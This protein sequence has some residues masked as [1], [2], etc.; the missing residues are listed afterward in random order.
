MPIFKSNFN[1]RCF[2]TTTRVLSTPYK[3]AIIGTG[4]G[5]FYTAHHLLNKSSSDKQIQLD[6]FEKLPTP[7]GLSRY[8]VAPDHPEVKNCES[9]M[10]DLMKD[11]G[12]KSNSKNRV[13]F[14]GNIEIGKDLSLKDLENH[15]NSIVLAYGCTS[16]DNKLNIPGSNLPGIISARKFVN[17]YNG[18]PDCYE[19]NNEYKPPP[20]DKIKNVSIIG[21][22]NVALDVARILLANPKTHWY[23][24]DISVDAEKLLE[25]SAVKNVNIVARRGILES[26]FSNKEIRELFELKDA[27]FKPLQQG[28]LESVSTQKLGRVDKRKVGLIEKYNK[29]IQNLSPE[30]RTWSLQYFKSPV[31]FIANKDGSIAETKCVVNKSVNDPLLPGRIEPT[32]KIVSI[33]NDLVILSIGYQG[34]PIKGFDEIGIWF[35]NNKLHNQNGRVLSTKTEGENDVNQTY[36]KGWY[37]SGWIKNGPKGVIA[38]TMMDSFDTASNIL[39][40]LSNGIHLEVDLNKDILDKIKDK[41]IVYWD[42]WENLNKFEL[43]KGKELGKSRYK[44]CEKDKMLKICE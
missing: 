17:W 29:P 3:I 12:Y 16:S 36:K 10:N 34:T 41:E 20:L 31:E 5:G 40:D 25:K 39:E 13:R 24:T 32:D 30:D 7:F 35:D 2:S 28:L 1:K 22:G 37:T 44:V 23:P 9:F 21:N 19:E 18:H 14:L 4:P 42:N 15:Y 11:H 38:V 8:G 27:K 33:K 26:A 6:F 43:D